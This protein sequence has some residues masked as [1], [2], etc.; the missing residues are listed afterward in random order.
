MP[1]LLPYAFALLT[2][3][4]ITLGISSSAKADQLLVNGGFETGTFAGWTVV[5]RTGSFAGSNFFVSAGTVLP[6]SGLSTVGPASGNFSAVS[7]Q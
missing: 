4:A 1:K 7:D 2:L 6:Q 5:N 3:I